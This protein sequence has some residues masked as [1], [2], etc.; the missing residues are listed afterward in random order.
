MILYLRFNGNA[1]AAYAITQQPDW[2]VYILLGEAEVR[3]SGHSVGTLRSDSFIGELTCFNGGAA[4]ATVTVTS[5]TRVFRI[6]SASLVKLC[7][8]SLELRIE[9][10]QAIRKDTGIKLVAANVQLSGRAANAGA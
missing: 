3:V 1:T 10:V 7:A 6:S 5:P 8:R 9:I 4:S 2:L